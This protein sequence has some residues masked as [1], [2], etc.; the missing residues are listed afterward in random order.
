MVRFY[1][2]A[3]SALLSILLPAGNANCQ[4]VNFSYSSLVGIQ[5]PLWIAKDLGF[6][7][8]HRIDANVVY[9]PG[10]VSVVQEMLAGR[11]QVAI[12]APAAVIRS[13]AGGSDLVYIGALSNRI[14]YVVVADKTIKSAQQLRGKKIAIGTLGAGPDY[15]GSIVF[16]KL[17]MRVGKDV[18]FVPTVGGQPT[19]LAM[20][21]SGSLDGVV[22]SPPYT[23]HAK[24]LG[25]V[26]VLDYA[27]V[28]PH[29]FS[30]GYFARR[31][32]LHDY[33]RAAENIVKALID[34]TR[35]VFSNPNETI[36]I[37]GRHL[38]ITDGAFLK[39]YYQEVLVG[40]LDRDLYA[41]S[42]AIDM[43]LEQEGKTNAAARK[44]MREDV[45]DTTV[46]D[47]LRREGY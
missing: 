20:L 24:Q 15:F 9:M 21:R 40:Q 33:P 29:F 28:I 8:K 34:A 42:K 18:T 37:L 3:M 7:K 5:S 46:L 11:L 41:D 4:N 25:F 12:A 26:A 45:F 14:D 43:L 6:F 38:Q 35:Y 36:E 27:S 47:K 32:Y 10:G 13:N 19:R 16:E 2:A 39:N 1:L 17:G 23:L 31:K 30:L 22:L 44:L